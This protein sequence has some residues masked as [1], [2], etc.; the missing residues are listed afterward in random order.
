MENDEIGRVFASQKES[1]LCG[2]DGDDDLVEGGVE[3][4][5]NNHK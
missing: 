1:K 2:D 3:R 4:Q 5:K